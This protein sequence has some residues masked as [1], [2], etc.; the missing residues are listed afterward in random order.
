[1]Y[2]ACGTAPLYIGSGLINGFPENNPPL[3]LSALFA[4][5]PALLG[6]VL[7]NHQCDEIVPAPPYFWP[8]LEQGVISAWAAAPSASE[9][10]VFDAYVAA[11]LGVTD[12]GARAAL[13]QLALDAIDAHLAMWT[14]AAFDP[15]VDP[16]QL[17]RPTAN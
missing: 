10:A 5:H 1:M 17:D 16:A 7:T 8:C 11:D 13:H 3:G 15:L 9:A 12:A 2:A 14:V 6:G 4:Q